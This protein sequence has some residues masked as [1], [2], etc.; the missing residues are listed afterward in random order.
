MD[1]DATEQVVARTYRH[2]ALGERR[3]IRLASDRLGEAEDLAMEFLGFRAPEV[4]API[5]LQQRRSLGFAAW[6]LI[7]DP[8]NARFALDLVKRMKA[9][10]RQARSKPGH[11]WDAYT[12]MAKDLGRSAR[13]F[14]PPFWEDA[15]RA[16]KDLGNPT[17][18]GRALTKSLEAERAHALPADRAR[19]RDVVLEFVLSGCI[20]GNA[21]SEYGNDL[22]S[23]YSPQEAFA[24]FRDLCVR[25]TRG[26]MSPWATLPKDFT[27][28]AKA[29][30][31]NGDA[32]LEK[33]LEELI[34]APA[35]GRL[36]HQ[37][38]KTC[39]AHCKRIVAR[40]PAFAVALLRHTRPEARYYGESKLGAWFELLE[41]WGVLAHLWEDEHQGAPPL[42]EPVANWFGRIVGDAVPAPKRTLEMLEKLVP[43]LRQ[44]NV[45]LPLLGCPALRHLGHRY[46]RAGSLPRPEAQGRGS[47]AGILGDIRRLVDRERGPSPPQPG[48]R[49]VVEGR[50]LQGR[51]APGA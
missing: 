46:R 6:A 37:F 16:F 34:D 45:P 32:E 13:H 22:Q 23:H 3:V 33:W 12:E 25:R 36:P 7:N 19:R 51:V 30:E 35:M 17:Y 14:L 40:N 24:I 41:E 50:T 18:A 47:S 8:G 48:H 9:A 2:P 43:R 29:A 15:G 28:L 27:K 4:S 31:L 20:S 42:G 38:W 26:G 49:C 11:A 21:L 10:A 5:A 1:A 39:S 44:E